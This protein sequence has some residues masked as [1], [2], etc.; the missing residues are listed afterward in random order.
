MELSADPSHARHGRADLAKFLAEHLDHDGLMFDADRG[1]RLAG[2][3]LLACYHDDDCPYVNVALDGDICAFLRIRF[4][5]FL[6]DPG[7]ST[8]TRAAGTAD[9]T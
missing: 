2:R 6:R 7:A 8:R 4:A 9:V 5:E 1:P 3:L